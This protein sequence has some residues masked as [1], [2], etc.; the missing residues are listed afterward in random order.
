M[1]GAENGRENHNQG[2]IPVLEQ[3]FGTYVIEQHLEAVA[4]NNCRWTPEY[5]RIVVNALVQGVTPYEINTQ[6]RKSTDFVG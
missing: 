1:K 2:S 4:V 6:T 5:E 3:N